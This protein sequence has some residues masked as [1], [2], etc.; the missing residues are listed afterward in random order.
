LTD[1]ESSFDIGRNEVKTA[2]PVMADEQRDGPV[3]NL[4][5]EM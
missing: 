3:G 2:G 4:K 1:D 5:D